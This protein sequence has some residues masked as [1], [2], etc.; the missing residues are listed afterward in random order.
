MLSGVEELIFG[1]TRMVFVVLIDGEVTHLAQAPSLSASGLQQEK[2]FAELAIVMQA[3]FDAEPVDNLLQYVVDMGCGQ[4]V[5][6]LLRR[7]RLPALFEPVN[8]TAGPLATADAR[9]GWSRSASW[10]AR[11]RC[12]CKHAGCR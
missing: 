9:G 6:D 5:L 4:P 11:C 7:G 2:Y 12:C 3:I 10:S 1:G 8:I